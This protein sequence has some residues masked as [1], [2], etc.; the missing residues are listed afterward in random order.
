MQNTWII[1]NHLENGKISEE[2]QV[3]LLICDLDNS[4]SWVLCI[5]FNFFSVITGYFKLQILLIFWKIV[6][7]FQFKVPAHSVLRSGFQLP[8]LYYKNARRN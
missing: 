3:F 8:V 5:V 6:I 2:V 4:I 1:S 7:T